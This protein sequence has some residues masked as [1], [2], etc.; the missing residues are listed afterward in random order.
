[1]CKPGGNN[2]GRKKRQQG[3]DKFVNGRV[4]PVSGDVF[5]RIFLQADH[6]ICIYYRVCH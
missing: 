4:F 3:K 6:G 2:K 1:M 5:E